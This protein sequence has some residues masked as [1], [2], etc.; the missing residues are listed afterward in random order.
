[1][2]KGTRMID[3]VQSIKLCA[4]YGVPAQYN[5]ITH[6]PGATADQIERTL[7]LLPALFGL[8]AP[9]LAHFYLDRGS[10]IFRDPRAHGLATERIDV[11]KLPFLP[12]EL[13]NDLSQVVPVAADGASDHADHWARLERLVAQWRSFEADRRAAGRAHGLSFRDTGG[14][15]ILLDARQDESFTL[16]LGGALRAILLACETIVSRNRLL[17]LFPGDPARLDAALA[18]LR[19]HR[20]ILEEKDLILALP[21]AA[22][23]PSGVHPAM[24]GARAMAT[25]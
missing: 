5:L 18:V 6:F 11:E 25:A 17:R 8:P 9:T 13:G 20:L 12:E 22:P 3:N 10:R 24:I 15:L 7:T 21:V 4:A 16:T 1:M 14:S 19:A 23:L 2:V